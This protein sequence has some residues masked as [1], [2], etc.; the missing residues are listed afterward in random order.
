MAIALA[1]CY[2]LRVETWHPAPAQVNDFIPRRFRLEPRPTH[3]GY[4]VQNLDRKVRWDLSTMSS[5]DVRNDGPFGSVSSTGYVGYVIKLGR[6][7]TQ[8]RGT[9]E[10]FND[11]QTRSTVSATVVVQR[12]GCD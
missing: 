7:G 10:Y 4:V 3:G 8:F 5:W 9:G 1:G 2:E 12:V 6:A 11:T